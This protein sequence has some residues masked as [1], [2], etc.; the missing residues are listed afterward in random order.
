M[1]CVNWFEIITLFCFV[2]AYGGGT[3]QAGCPN[4]RRCR[5]HSSFPYNYKKNKGEKR[6]D[7]F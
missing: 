7:N 1:N 2:K 5:F 4:G 6:V 3:D